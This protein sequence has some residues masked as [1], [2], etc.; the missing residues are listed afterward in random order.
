[1]RTNLIRM[2]GENFTLPS[3]N[4][5]DSSRTNIRGEEMLELCK[6]HN[7]NKL[8][9]RK[10]GDHW[11]KLTSFQWNGSAIVDYVLARIDFYND[12]TS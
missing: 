9:G 2:L 1:M 12:I 6:Y 8:N 10:T 11:G 4:S 3:R 7:L 5:E